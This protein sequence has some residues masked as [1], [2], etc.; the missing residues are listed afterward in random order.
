MIGPLP[1]DSSEDVGDDDDDVNYADD[2]YLD[3]NDDGYLQIM[4][5]MMIV[6]INTET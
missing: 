1:L 4:R 2:D 6:N 3:D 5:E